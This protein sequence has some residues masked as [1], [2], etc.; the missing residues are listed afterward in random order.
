MFNIAPSFKDLKVFGSLCFASTLSH[1]RS[2]FDSRA[3]KCVFLG[4]PIGYKAFTLLDLT[5]NQIFYSRDVAFH[6]FVFPFKSDCV[7]SL[8]PSVSISEPTIQAYPTFLDDLD[9]PVLSDSHITDSSS[10]SPIITPS[11][12][13]PTSSS[14][15]PSLRRSS[16]SHHTPSYLQDYHCALAHHADQS[17]NDIVPRYPPLKVQTRAPLKLQTI[18]LISSPV[19]SIAKKSVLLSILFSSK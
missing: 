1:N 13:L 14:P 8:S 19:A 3:R 10:S 5:S 9:P 18:P 6:E 15:S 17:S 4:F 12:S 7:T 2:K 11:S 16:R